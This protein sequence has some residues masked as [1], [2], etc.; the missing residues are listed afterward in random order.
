[1]RLE[2]EAPGAVALIALLRD[3]CGVGLG[4]DM[5]EGGAEVGSV[6]GGMSRRLGGVNVLALRAVKLDALRMWK[7]RETDRKEGVRAAE[8]TRTAAK[9]AFLIFIELLGVSARQI[10]GSAEELYHL[11]QPPSG[12]DVPRVHEPVQVPRGFLNLVSYIV[13]AI[14]FEDVCDEVKG[15]LVVLDFGL[16]AGEVEAVGEILFI[17]FAEVLMAAGRDE[18]VPPVTGVVGVCL[19]VE[20]LH[21]V[22]P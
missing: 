4:Q 5:R 9:V 3:Q 20:F 15:I 11:L 2:T 19:R 1:V 17:D 8:H 14:E 6:D 7:I 21:C 18:P 13:V 12:N 22:R 10:R 16:E